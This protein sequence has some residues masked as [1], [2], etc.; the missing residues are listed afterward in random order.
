MKVRIPV[1]VAC[2]AA[3]LAAAELPYAGKWKLNPSRSDFGQTT[4]TY[5]QLSSG[6]MKLTAGGQSY[7]FKDDSK[8][9]PTP[10]GSTASYKHVDDRTWETAETVNGKVIAT[11]TM[12]LSAD[13]KVLNVAI[14]AAK[15]D[16]G[17]SDNTAVYQRVSGGPGLLGKWKTR[18]VKISS[19]GTV[20]IASS[21]ADGL[22]LKFVD[23]GGTCDA[24]FDG[25]DYPATGSMWPAGW[26]CSVAKAGA[27]TFN[28]TWK[29]DGKLMFQG[30]FTVSPDGRT[31]TDIESSPG[32]SE[33]VKA[34]YDRQPVGTN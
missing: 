8:E 24:Q 9:Y 2:A 17:T 21:G 15:A 1:L 5:E 25:K 19:P 6:E 7:T 33:K 16:G 12:K 30:V 14:K 13:G 11:A 28:L 32:T 26:T 3:A 31:L 20:A 10:W 29:K 23:E 27:R 4:M 18:N 22:L 34:V